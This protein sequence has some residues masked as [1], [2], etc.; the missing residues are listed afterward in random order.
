MSVTSTIYP[1]PA[2]ESEVGNRDD[3]HSGFK[4]LGLNG[5]GK[6]GKEVTSSGNMINCTNKIG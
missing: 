6:W 2:C 5:H 3:L 4:A 1:S